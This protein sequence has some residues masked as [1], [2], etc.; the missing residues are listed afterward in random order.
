MIAVTFALPAESSDF[1]KLLQNPMRGRIGDAEFSC[2]SIDRKHVCVLHTGVGE[3]ATR[4]RV[5]H[6]LAHQ[7]AEMLISSGF[8]GGVSK[9][10]GL[11]DLVIADN[12]SDAAVA[13]T[14]AAVLANSVV[15]VGELVTAPAI[16]DSPSDRAAFACE[17]G[18]I[19]VDMETEFIAVE[20]RSRSVPMLSLRAISDTVAA[21]LPAP[22]SV[23]FDIDQQKTNYSS[24]LLHLA[25][26]PS[27]IGRLARF[28]K[29]VSTA[30][31]SLTAALQLLLQSDVV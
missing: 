26:H 15:H 10:L 23:L 31:R 22:G 27:A 18:A 13:K 30:R 28:T 24:L 9:Q 29:Q 25:K 1:I 20:C 3:K 2:G 21:P 17:R 14:A 6:F 19:A 12:F 7:R 16:V 5:Q 11:G 8:A 4:A